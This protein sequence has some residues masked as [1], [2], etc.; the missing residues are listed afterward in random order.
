MNS[1]RRSFIRV[2]SLALGASCLLP[3]R[4]LFALGADKGVLSFDAAQM[5]LLDFAASYGTSVRLTGISVL[6]RLHSGR[7]GVHLL[8]Q[9]NDFLKFGNAILSAPSKNFF[10]NGNTLS[11][12]SVGSA[13][14][15]ENLSVEDFSA[16]LGQLS[17]GEN[18][19]FAHDALTY[20]P[21]AKTFSDPFGAVEAGEL[22]L[23]N[24][25]KKT[26]EA[27]EVV[28]RGTG[29]A[30]AA[31]IA[32]GK[33]F[34][35]WK[36]QIVKLT[37]HSSAAVPIAAVFVRNLPGF[38][39][40]AGTEEVKNAVTTP[41]VSSAVQSAL[42]MNSRT[43]IAEFDRVRAIF[44]ESYSDGAVWLYVLLW[45]QL[46]TATPEWLTSGLFENGQWREAFKNAGLIEEAFK[47]PQLKSQA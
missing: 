18:I 3:H 21:A 45:K 39:A 14:L 34:A 5:R 29:G 24:R 12:A 8:V 15:I 36:S 37:V 17:R 23:I 9:V 2:G 4:S 32:E 6:S 41:L 22:K 33:E 19:A 20:D 38:A 1:N 11:F 43:A 13:S 47:S 44:G 30:R 27:L 7:G 26:Q 25:P 31:G 28:L 10:A 42:G 16:R 46:K 40:L 35:Q